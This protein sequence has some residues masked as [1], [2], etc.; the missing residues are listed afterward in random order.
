MSAGSVG[1]EYRVENVVCTVHPGR[2]LIA[3]SYKTVGIRT[4]T[5][6]VLLEVG[7]ENVSKYCIYSIDQSDASTAH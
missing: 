1:R 4:L 6:D 7:N 2:G 3:P 5:P